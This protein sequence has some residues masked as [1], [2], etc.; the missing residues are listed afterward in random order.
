MIRRQFSLVFVF[1]FS[2]R[3]EFPKLRKID[4]VGIMSSGPSQ[5]Q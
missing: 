1:V 5:G 3:R 2:I 4:H